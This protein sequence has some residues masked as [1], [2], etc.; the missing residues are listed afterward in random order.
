MK[1]IVEALLKSLGGIANVGIVILVIWLMF[2]ILAVNLFSGTLHYCT[3][4]TYEISTE[5]ECLASRGTWKNF[6]W[7]WDDTPHAILLLFN[8][9]TE[10]NWPDFMYNQICA[11]GADVGP[12]FWHSPFNGLFF[13]VFF[14]LNNFLFLNLFIGVIF[15]EFEDA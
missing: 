2:A 14:L 10:E 3:N 1:T 8:L 6:D 15:K 4:N 12:K 9:S 11:V 13:I 5:A 7:N